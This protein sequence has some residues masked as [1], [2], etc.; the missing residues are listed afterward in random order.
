MCVAHLYGPSSME[1]RTGHVICIPLMVEFEALE[2]H[3]NALLS[4]RRIFLLCK[5]K[6]SALSP[7]SASPRSADRTLSDWWKSIT[8]L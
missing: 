7:L 1:D 6:Q 4:S 5:S 3:R 2:M 8:E